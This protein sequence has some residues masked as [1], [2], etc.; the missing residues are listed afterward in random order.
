MATL[1]IDIEVPSTP[2]ITLKIVRSLI[3]GCEETIIGLREIETRLMKKQEGEE[4]SGCMP[5]SS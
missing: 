3:A 1:K 5:T 2:D 4:K